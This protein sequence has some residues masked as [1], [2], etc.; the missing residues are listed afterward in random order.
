M[1]IKRTDLLLY[2][3]ATARLCYYI[4]ITLAYVTAYY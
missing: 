4:I 3:L 1:E 2:Y